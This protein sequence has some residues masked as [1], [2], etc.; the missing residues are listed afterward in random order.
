MN[1]CQQLKLSHRIN[2][3]DDRSLL[4]YSPDLKANRQ[5]TKIDTKVI[6]SPKQTLPLDKFLNRLDP[7]TSPA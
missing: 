4:I 7:R 2:N 3:S 5:L 1:K 6:M